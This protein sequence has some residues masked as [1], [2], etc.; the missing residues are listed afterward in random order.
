MTFQT[1]C[2]FIIISK[3][4]YSSSQYNQFLKNVYCQ[5]YLI[6]LVTHVNFIP[7]SEVQ[8]KLD[9]TCSYLLIYRNPNHVAVCSD[10]LRHFFGMKLRSLRVNCNGC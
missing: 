8:R 1:L 4:H 5:K 2:S 6:V 10:I 9:Q 7:N 3:R